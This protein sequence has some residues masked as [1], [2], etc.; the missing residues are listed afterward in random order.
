MA[1]HPLPRTAS[2]MNEKSAIWV[3]W[4]YQTR[5]RSLSGLLGIPLYEIVSENRGVRR[6]F[7]SL[8]R[9]LRLI[10][11][12]TPDVVFCQNPSM[13][14]SLFCVVFKK[15]FSYSVIVDEHNAG[16][17][18]VE[19]KSELLNRIARYI[20]RKA[21]AVI[22]TNSPLAQQCT[23]WGGNP[24]ILEDPLP[25][26]V[27]E[28]SIVPPVISI[29]KNAPYK[30]LFICTWASDE[31]YMNVLRAIEAFPA[32]TLNV[33]ITGN[34]S[35][36]VNVSQVPGSVHLTGFL[37]KADY[38]KQ[39]AT[40]DGV[41]VL[42]ARQDCLNCGAYEAVSLMKPGIL[43]DTTALR[44]YFTSGFLFTDNSVDSLIRNI[45]AL[46]EQHHALQTGL[47]G[48]KAKCE[49]NDLANRQKLGNFLARLA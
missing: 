13:V 25:N 5:N 45:Q 20:V 4:E 7:E 23:Q 33:T 26:F 15:L 1:L 49:E 8:L 17:F 46:M 37:S 11:S 19:G 35:G 10:R 16:L 40:A 3:T 27:E 32:E 28:Y 12:E 44:G 31:P 6:Y 34:Y 48:L 29:K 42:T 47:Q 18:P 36:K 2:T 9:T 43:S 21:D 39:L 38:V 14:L 24:I 41:V 22:V 30:L